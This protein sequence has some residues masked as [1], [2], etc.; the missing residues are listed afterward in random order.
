M[1][2][3]IE[4]EVGLLEQNPTFEDT[5]LEVIKACLEAEQ[6]PYD[7]EISLTIVDE[8]TIHQ[9]NNEHRGVD[10]ATDVLSFPQLETPINWS[11]VPTFMDKVMLG[12]IVL[13]DEVAKK[14]AM[15]YNHSLN[16]EVSFLVAHSMFHLLGYDHMTE[17]EEKVMIKKQEDVLNKLMITR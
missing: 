8:E 14:Q 10:K 4:D 15:E 1:D 11:D 3:Q 13:C 7:A 2:I 17:D 12:D 16:R 6:V 9:I 5:I